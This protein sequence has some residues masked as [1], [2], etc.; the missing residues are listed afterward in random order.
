MIR[1]ETISFLN[2]MLTAPSEKPIRF[3]AVLVTQGSPGDGRTLGDLDLRNRTGL[4]V[5]ALCRGTGPEFQ[6][7]PGPGTRLA[8][9]DRLIV[10]G[11]RPAVGRMAE[12]VGRRE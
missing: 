2:E 9:G 7:N 1:P 12:V 6:C 3:E 10:I 4:E 5:V 8:A 11:D